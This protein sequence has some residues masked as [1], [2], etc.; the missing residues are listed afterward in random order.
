MKDRAA[1]EEWAARTTRTRL[2]WSNFRFGHIAPLNRRRGPLE[3][4]LAAILNIGML[5]GRVGTKHPKTRPP[6]RK[7]P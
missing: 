1:F 3:R 2:A 6:K 4:L 7:T 5:F